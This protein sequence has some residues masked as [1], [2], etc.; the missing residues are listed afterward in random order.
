M[1]AARYQSLKKS[2]SGLSLIELMI[3]ISI[4]SLISSVILTI[5]LSMQKSLT[6]QLAL[7][8][9][10]HNSQKAHH[11]FKYAIERSGYLSCS[12]IN[13]MV[14]ESQNE[15]IVRYVDYPGC[16]LL[17]Q[18]HQSL[19]SVDLNQRFSSRDI[20][21]ISDC[22]HAEMLQVKKVI[23]DRDKQVITTE[24]PLHYPYEQHAEIG[25]FVTAHFFVKPT[26]RFYKDGSP[27]YGLF[28]ANRHRSEE[29]LEGV[30][31]MQVLL[32]GTSGV[33]IDLQF[34]S[35]QVTKNV[36]YYYSLRGA[37]A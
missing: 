1:L 25:R 22:H 6:L 24:Q 17:K 37:N 10:Q 3:A 20:L 34:K 7:N 2:I 15:L 9:I 16:S 27:I 28:I 29:L 4:A 33:E 30:Q 32:K 21:V 26:N 19:L 18:H 13:N 36:H 35:E 5:Y 14:S 31:F 12:R 8:N 11:I 23:H